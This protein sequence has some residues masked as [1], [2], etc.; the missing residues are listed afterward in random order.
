MYSWRYEGDNNIGAE[1]CEHLSK[2]DWKNLTSLNL[3]G[4]S[5]DAEACGHLSKANWKSLS[6]LR[7]STPL[8]M[9]I[10]TNSLTK[11]S[12]LWPRLIGQCSLP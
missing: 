1:G 7:L 3:E 10:K 8:G 5:I 2:A 11:A 4:N 9:K 12:R 6:Y